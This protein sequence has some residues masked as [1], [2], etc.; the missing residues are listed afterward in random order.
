LYRTIL[1]HWFG[2]PWALCAAKFAEIEAFLRT[3]AAGLDVPADRVAAI[4]AAARRSNGAQ[5][6]AGG[7]AILP[8]MGVLSQR[9]SQLEEASGGV[10][11]EAIG[12]QLDALVADRSVRRIVMQFDSPGG[13]VYGIQ[14][15]AAKIRG[16]RQDKAIYAIADPVAASAALWL[17][18]QAKEFYVT[19]SGQVGSIGVIASHADYSAANEMEGV[20]VTTVTAGKYKAE[21]SPD[22]PLS[23]EAVNHMQGKVDAYYASFVGDVAKGR[24]VTE[25]A[26]RSD[27]GQ[28]RMMLAGDAKRAGLVDGVATLEALLTRISPASDRPAAR[29]VV[30][31]DV[32]RATARAVELGIR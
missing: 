22:A 13:S 10:S 21:G 19:P 3:K 8:V 29:A 23:E 30:A 1:S 25:A 5:I 15:L 28:G 31:G 24:S 18:T 11:S 26:V 20:K 32:V 16:A 17:G 14:E 9:V 7:V 6:T 4:T 2:H 12:A 27:F